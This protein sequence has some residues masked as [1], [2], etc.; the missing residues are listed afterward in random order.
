MSGNRSVLG[1]GVALCTAA[2]AFTAGAAAVP[3]AGS[4]IDPGTRVNGMLVVQGTARDADAELFGVTCDPV[5]V[6]PGRRTRLCGTL[7]PV[8]RIFVGHGVWAVSRQ[9]LESY[10]SAYARLTELWI[11]GQRVRLDRFGH[12]DRWLLAYPPADGRDALLRQWSIILVGA[13][14]RHSIRYRGRSGRGVA[15]T[16]WRFSVA[17]S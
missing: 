3:S 10:W 4:A 8:R 6:R 1:V 13:E 2:L 9:L 16:T 17:R 7:P 14:G 11:D 15:D 5:V 12:S